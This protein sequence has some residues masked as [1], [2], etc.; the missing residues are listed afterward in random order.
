MGPIGP[1]PRA[2]GP[3]RGPRALGH[4][5]LGP[6]PRALGPHGAPWGPPW[7][8]KSPIQN[9]FSRTIRNE[10]SVLEVTIARPCQAML[11]YAMLCHAMP[12]MPCYAMLCHAMPCYA[13]LCHAM[14]CYAMLCFA[15]TERGSWK[16]IPPPQ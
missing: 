4:G 8:P 16:E 9:Q 7:A 15:G 2:L 12:C 3:I 1:G 11:C 14:P 13:M 10:C 5:A 6:G